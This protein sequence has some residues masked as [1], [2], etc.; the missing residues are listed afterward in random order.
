ME[1]GKLLFIKKKQRS[2]VRRT[3]GGSNNDGQFCVLF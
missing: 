1:E 2:H 3:N